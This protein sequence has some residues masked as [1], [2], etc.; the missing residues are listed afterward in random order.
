[1]YASA[2]SLAAINLDGSVFKRY[3]SDIFA[4]MKKSAFKP[5]TLKEAQKAAKE[6]SFV[7]GG[8]EF[9]CFYFE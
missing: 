9:T 4:N 5:L 3:A 8:L 1:L 2:L 6:G 7:Y